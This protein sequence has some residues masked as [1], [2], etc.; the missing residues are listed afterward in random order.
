[1]VFR[2]TATVLGV[3]ALF[4]SGCVSSG[5]YQLKEQESQLLSKNLEESR[6]QYG[7]LQKK[8]RQL[9]DENSDLTSSIRKQKGELA[10]AASRN[11]KLAATNAELTAQSKALAADLADARGEVER[12]IQANTDLSEKMKKLAVDFVDL[13]AERDKVSQANLTLFGKVGR[14]AGEISELK[15]AN[16]KLANAAK[17]ENLLKTVGEYFEAQQK[18]LDDLKEE[19][20]RLKQTL[21]EMRGIGRLPGAESSSRMPEDKPAPVAAK[22]TASPVAEKKQPVQV[23]KEKPAPLPVAVEKVSPVVPAMEKPRPATMVSE[24]PHHEP[25]KAEG[26]DAPTIIHIPGEEPIS[27][28]LE[29]EK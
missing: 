26:E 12:K 23:Q 15:A 29:V 21:L 19:N 14:Q 24:A 1:M 7:D 11:E 25:A 9:E 22:P 2:F 18:K 13:K 3:G 8:Y 17:P 4:L 27:L 6:R 10:E 20:A 16:E 5:T 28:P